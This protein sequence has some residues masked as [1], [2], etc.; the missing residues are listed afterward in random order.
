MTNALSR[1]ALLRSGASLAAL[2]LCPPVGRSHP[3][4]AELNFL[5]IGDWGQRNQ[6]Q[7]KVAA[8]LAAAARDT[9]PRFVISTGDNIYAEGVTS[10]EDPLWA[11]TFENV[12]S[13]RHL[14]CVWYA[15]LGNH[16]HEGNADAQIAYSRESPRWTMP[17]RYYTRT[18][19]IADD[20]LAEFFFLDTTEL[21]RDDGA[22]LTTLRGDD[23]STQLQWLDRKLAASSARWKI[24]IGHHPVYSGGPHE[25]SPILTRRLE[26]LL[27]RHGVAAYV[28]GHDHNLQ[29]IEVKGVH[30]LTSGA[31]SEIGTP[32]DTPATRFKAAS[33]GF[34]S[35]R[36]ARDAATFEFVDADNRVLDRFEIAARA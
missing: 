30:Y 12:Y 29:H 17:G 14:M 35:A 16:D 2:T 3:A 13:D 9:H 1:R 4:E 24:V 27:Q 5:V 10:A 31:G 32:R 18:E 7:H 34:L 20:S 26:P 28:N 21:A 6:N 11:E 25:A 33:L 36:L 22:V 8:A 15:V 23:T 19:T